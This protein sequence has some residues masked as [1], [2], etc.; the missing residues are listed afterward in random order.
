[1]H[2]LASWSTR[3]YQ[4]CSLGGRNGYGAKL[5]NIFS[6]K[7][8]V[9][10]ACKESKKSFKQV[11]RHLNHIYSFIIIV[12]Y[13]AKMSQ[14]ALVF[15]RL[16]MITWAGQGMLASNPLMERNTLASPSGQICPSLK[17]A[18]WTKTQWL[19]WPGG[20]MTFLDPV[21]VSVCSSMARSCQ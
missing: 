15:H 12:I 18:S 21:K 13:K 10:T 16:G 5:C 19:L 2:F 8:T 11:G 17:W 7:F 6:T 20:P 9:E 14:Y 4:Y 3:L 1:M